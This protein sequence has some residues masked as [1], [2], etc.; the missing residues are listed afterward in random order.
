MVNVSEIIEKISLGQIHPVEFTIL[1]ENRRF[2][3]RDA[4]IQKGTAPVKKPTLRG[5]VYFS[6]LNNYTLTGTVTD[7]EILPLLSGK[8]LGPNTEFAEI[9]VFAKIM[10]DNKKI[11]FTTN[12]TN[13]MQN[14]KKIVLNL[15]ITRT[16]ID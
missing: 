7:F 5:G 2:S 10:P 3:I 8:M 6:D 1:I 13:M 14:S 11:I 4:K 15:V 16:E 12:L 9:P